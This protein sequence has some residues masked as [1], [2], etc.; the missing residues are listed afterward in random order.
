M[1]I[2]HDQA[3][4]L[5]I[6]LAVA[7][8]FVV[9]L[10]NLSTWCSAATLGEL[11]LVIALGAYCSPHCGL[12][13][14]VSKFPGQVSYKTIK[15]TSHQL[16]QN[17]THLILFTQ[18][19][20]ETSYAKLPTKYFRYFNWVQRGFSDCCCVVP[21]SVTAPPPP[22]PPP[23]VSEWVASIVRPNTAVT[24]SLAACQLSAQAIWSYCLRL[25]KV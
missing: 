19:Y 25:T 20:Y 18:V 1:S 10:V 16:E 21:R 8:V 2:I 15:R 7:I 3:R 4:V 5:I 12:I 13:V 9:E 6:I 17:Y 14:S 24:K 11:R 23:P 22:P